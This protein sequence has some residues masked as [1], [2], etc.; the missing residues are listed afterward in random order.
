MPLEEYLF[1]WIQFL[2]PNPIKSAKFKCLDLL[3]LC[4]RL[5]QQLFCKISITKFQLSK[6]HVSKFPFGH[7]KFDELHRL[8]SLTALADRGRGRQSLHKSNIPHLQRAKT[9]A[10]LVYIYSFS[11]FLKAVGFVYE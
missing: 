8:H 3:Y 6:F 5:F 2:L 10:K 9:L 4:L 11:S 1:A 7:M